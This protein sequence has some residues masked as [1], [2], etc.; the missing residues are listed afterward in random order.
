MQKFYLIAA[1]AMLIV[2]AMLVLFVV[3]GLLVIW[4]GHFLHWPFVHNFSFRVLHLMAIGCVTVQTL[5]GFDCPLTTWEDALR[6]KA[7]FESRYTEGCIAYWV[8]RLLFYEADQKVFAAI[9]VAFFGLVG[10][11]FVWIKP[12][13]PAWWKHWRKTTETR[14]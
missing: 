9:Y 6:T 7:G 3:G 8:H 13:T 11:S 5:A 1:D 14:R 4:T 2:H 10:A 12:Q